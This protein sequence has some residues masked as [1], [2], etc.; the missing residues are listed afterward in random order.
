MRIDANTDLFGQP[1][2]IG[3]FGVT[4]IGGQRD[5]NEPL[6]DGYTITPR[7]QFDLTEPV[8]A[9]FSVVSPWDGSTGA[10]EIFNLSTGAGGYLWAMGD[11]ASY[12]AN[13]P[14]HYYTAPGTFE[15]TLTAY[16]EDGECSTQTT[17]EV[18]STWVGVEEVKTPEFHVYPN[19]SS[20]VV[21]IELKSG[22]VNSWA[23][24]DSKGKLVINEQNIP[25]DI[26][27]LSVSHLAPGFYTLS[28]S[29]GYSPIRI[30]VQ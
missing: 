23:M 22:P 20:T 8:V 2:P 30:L 14:V 26:I 13:I 21:T 1:A 7:G 19:P 3:V 27:R 29:E 6:V 15:I 12:E 18:E 28:L 4:G 25:A 11:G 24:Y 17:Q 16:S 5:Y 9:D 10:V